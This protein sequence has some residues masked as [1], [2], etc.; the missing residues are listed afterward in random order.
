MN[1]EEVYTKVISE[2]ERNYSEIVVTPSTIIPFTIRI[3]SLLDKYT[4]E[5]GE[6]KR[7]ILYAILDKVLQDFEV[8]DRQVVQDFLAN[9]LPFLIDNVI[10][11][12]KNIKGFKINTDSIGRKFK[13][14]MK[15]LSCKHVD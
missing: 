2:L 6:N 5:T 14:F 8:R 13:R 7:K 4:T 1:Q 11:V 12:S 10:Y 3:M 15:K 9:T